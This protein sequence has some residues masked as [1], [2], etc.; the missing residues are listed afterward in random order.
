MIGAVSP[1]TLDTIPVADLRH[2]AISSGPMI[3]RVALACDSQC[4][5]LMS[6]SLPKWRLILCL[7][8]T[9]A[10]CWPDVCLAQWAPQG[11]VFPPS[12]S[13]K[14]SV[15]VHATPR[16]EPVV[17]SAIHRHHRHSVRVSVTVPSFIASVTITNRSHKASAACA[18]SCD[19]WLMP[20]EYAVVV[21]EQGGSSSEHE[22]DLRQ[23]TG[24]TFTKADEETAYV[25]LT[26]GLLGPLVAL[27]GAFLAAVGNVDAEGNAGKLAFNPVSTILALGGAGMTTVGWVLYARNRNV[28]VNERALSA[29]WSPENIR[30]A[31]TPVSQGMAIGAT[32]SF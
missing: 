5:G 29:K 15:P 24:I 30:V 16:T 23:S 20:G 32:V 18:A 19:L 3:A 17:A 27:S 26:M 6:E 9:V 2:C 12:T 28:A 4:G 21:A 7:L 10:A 22:L 1:G 14:P 13:P 8:V 25:G 31:A 11:L